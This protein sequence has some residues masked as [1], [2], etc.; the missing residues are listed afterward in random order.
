M[1]STHDVLNDAAIGHIVLTT[2][3]QSSPLTIIKPSIKEKKMVPHDQT[4]QE[5]VEVIL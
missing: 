2:F 1:I 3:K 4:F 5:D